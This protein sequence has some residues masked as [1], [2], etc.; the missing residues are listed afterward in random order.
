ML[1][2]PVVLGADVGLQHR[3]RQVRVVPRRQH[4]ADVV[5]QRHH[6]HLLVGAVAVGAGRALQAVLVAVDLVAELV[7]GEPVQRAQD[8]VR[9]F[10]FQFLVVPVEELILFARALI[11]ADE[12]DGLGF[13]HVFTS[14]VLAGVLA[15]FRPC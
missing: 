15:L 12:A 11:H 13:K 14:P 3:R 10:V 6:H 9:Q 2:Q 7:A 1:H 5:E 8:V 4:V